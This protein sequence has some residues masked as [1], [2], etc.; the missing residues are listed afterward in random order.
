MTGSNSGKRKGRR[1]KSPLK[2]WHDRIKTLKGS[3]FDPKEIHEQIIA[4]E[5]SLEGAPYVKGE[6]TAIKLSILTYY[7]DIYTSI[8]K[9]HFKKNICYVD[10][11]AGPGIVIIKEKHGKG[12]PIYLYGSPALAVFV[13]KEKVKFD[14]YIFVEKDVKRSNYL[15]MVMNKLSEQGYIDQKD[16]LIINRDM[17]EISYSY[18]LAKNW[19]NH[20]LVFIDPEGL[21]PKWRTVYSILSLN[22]DVLLSFI[23]FGVRRI[24]GKALKNNEK[25]KEL[26]T[27]FYGDESWRYASDSEDLLDR[28]INK[29]KEKTRKLVLPIKVRISP[30]IYYD[31][32]LVTRRTK[33]GSPYLQPVEI[34][35]SKIERTKPKDFVKILDVIAGRRAT[36]F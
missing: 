5:P 6:W 8:I 21:E 29:I 7:M 19:C 35:K 27:E 2:W 15:R 3:G 24:W 23:S 25:E 32:I 33:R 31:V 14:K 13:P 1:K 17:N 4:E 20:S 9:K 11:F 22:A 34:L 10:T 18:I 36:L 28:Y 12:N 16:Y 30:S 26:I